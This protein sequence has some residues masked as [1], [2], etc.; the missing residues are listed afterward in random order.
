MTT[1][2]LGMCFALA[3][4][5]EAK[6][7]ADCKDWTEGVMEINGGIITIGKTQIDEFKTVTGFDEE[8]KVSNYSDGRNYY[9]LTDGYSEIEV[10]AQSD[11]RVTYFFA[12]NDGFDGRHIDFEH[13]VITGP[14]GITAGSS[15]VEDLAEYDKDLEGRYN[16]SVYDGDNYCEYIAGKA[17]GTFGMQDE[18][19]YSVDGDLESRVI[20]EIMLQVD[21]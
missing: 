18:Y 9:Y 21:E 4:C 15:K 13:T 5:G 6:S 17:E 19:I 7:P 2:L 10:L 12:S 14:G 16:S 8:I 11:G 1:L 3:G 20:Y